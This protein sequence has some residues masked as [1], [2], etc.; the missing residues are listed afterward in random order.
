MI[1]RILNL[2]IGVLLLAGYAW[3]L[4]NLGHYFPALAEIHGKPY[5]RAAFGMAFIL[6]LP[7]IGI[8]CILAPGTFRNRFSPHYGA[9]DHAL[10]TDGFWIILGYLMLGLSSAILLLFT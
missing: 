4:L 6:I 3:L 1:I 7:L 5:P 2:L 9:G 8:A 10:L